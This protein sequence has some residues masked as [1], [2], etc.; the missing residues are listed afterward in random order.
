MSLAGRKS[1]AQL[2]RYHYVV[3][4]VIA[5]CLKLWHPLNHCWISQ[6]RQTGRPF[7]FHMQQRDAAGLLLPISVQPGTGC[8]NLLRRPDGYCTRLAHRCTFRSCREWCILRDSCLLGTTPTMH[9]PE[10]KRARWHPLTLD[11]PP[12]SLNRQGWC[13]AATLLSGCWTQTQPV[14][15]LRHEA[16]SDLLRRSMHGAGVVQAARLR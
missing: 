1:L 2:A 15:V 6:L 3:P 14:S 9:Q 16:W 5:V 7:C 8:R 11:R 4:T 12:R 10:F 13:S